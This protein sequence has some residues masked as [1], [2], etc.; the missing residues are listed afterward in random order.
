MRGSRE[1]TPAERVAA[2]AE[3]GIGL[4]VVGGSLRARCEPELVLLLDA[5]RPVLCWHRSALVRYLAAQQSPI[6]GVAITA[7]L[8][9][10]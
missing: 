3:R 8:A 7:T 6:S 4:Y 2:F 5:A 1:L 10:D 9:E